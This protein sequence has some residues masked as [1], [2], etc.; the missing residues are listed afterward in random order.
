MYSSLL[1]YYYV[2]IVMESSNLEDLSDNESDDEDSEV[3][4]VLNDS[5][6]QQ[7]DVRRGNKRSAGNVVAQQV[8][9]LMMTV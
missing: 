9:E 2:Q 8:T 7:A 6:H 4:D 5:C 3:D 1:N